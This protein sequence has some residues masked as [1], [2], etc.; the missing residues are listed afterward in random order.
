MVLVISASGEYVG[1]YMLPTPPFWKFGISGD[2]LIIKAENF[3][4][5]Q[6]DFSDKTPP[7]AIVVDGESDELFK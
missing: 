5:V 1:R 6:I 3:D 4:S 7:L 2:N